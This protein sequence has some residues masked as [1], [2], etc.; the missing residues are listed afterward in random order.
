MI[1]TENPRTEN[2]ASL[3]ISKP[4]PRFNILT[5][6]GRP[7]HVAFSDAFTPT[8]YAVSDFI[9]IG[10]GNEPGQIPVTN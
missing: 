4:S 9:W 1:S 7:I 2:D 6:R 5:P 10:L 8:K 3:E